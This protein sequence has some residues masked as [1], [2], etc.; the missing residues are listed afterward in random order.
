MR[1]SQLKR[2]H[3]TTLQCV[4]CR[5]DVGTP[6]TNSVP[7]CTLS[8][9][10]KKVATAAALTSLVRK[11]ARHS[12]QRDTACDTV[13]TQYL[14]LHRVVFLAYRQALN[15][16]QASYDHTVCCT[17]AIAT[18]PVHTMKLNQLCLATN[19]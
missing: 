7:G 1:Q 4:M 3:Y 9:L 6:D 10:E 12:T 19:R 15:P 2:T 5:A 14:L 8:I 11:K 16:I 18:T 13:G 17:W